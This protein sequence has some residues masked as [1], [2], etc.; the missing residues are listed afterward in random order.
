MRGL[1]SPRGG[2]S[3]TGFAYDEPVERDAVLERVHLGG[4]DVDAVCRERR[5]EQGEQAGPVRGDQ[6]QLR[7]AGLR[8]PQ[9]GGEPGA[10][11]H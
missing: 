1:P 7:L 10:A 6:G 4:E 11:R 8:L 3:T 5:G 2:S 9:L